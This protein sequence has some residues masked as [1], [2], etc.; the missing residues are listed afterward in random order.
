ME[1]TW[2]RLVAVL[3]LPAAAVIASVL[4]VEEALFG[5]PAEPRGLYASLAYIGLWCM[6][7][8]GCRKSRTVMRLSAVCSVLTLIPSACIVLAQICDWQIWRPLQWMLPFAVPMCGLRFFLESE[9]ALQTGAVLLLISLIW[10]ALSIAFLKKIKP[11]RRN[12]T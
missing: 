2:K 7:L 12:K 11:V 5:T 8:F 1:W 9:D 3:L 10:L 6:V 4:N